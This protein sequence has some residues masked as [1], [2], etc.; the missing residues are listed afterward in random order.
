MSGRLDSLF[1]LIGK[2]R[3]PAGGPPEY[4]IVGLGNPGGQYEGSRHNAGFMAIDALARERDAA[5]RRIGFQ[6]LY[7]MTEMAGRRVLLLKP[8]TFMNLSGESVRD[9]AKFYKIPMERVIVLVDDVDLPV[10]RLRVR[11]KGS[12]GGHNGLKNII[13]QTGTDVFPRVRIGV[14]PKP[15]RDY[16]LAEWVLGRVPPE[17]RELFAGALAR[18]G[19]AAADIIEKGVSDAMNCYNA[20]PAVLGQQPGPAGGETARNRK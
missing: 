15:R 14:D 4:M 6:A 13:Y 5:I 7:G 20:D 18:A 3:K 10:G 9:A 11:A 16:D 8:Q 12:A 19:Q 2:D 1:T 17:K